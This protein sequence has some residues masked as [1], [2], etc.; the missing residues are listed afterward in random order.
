V[1]HAL[2]GREETVLKDALIQLEVAGLVFRR[3]EPSETIYSFKHALVQDAAYESMLKSR[4]QVLHQRI[5]ETLCERFP[6]IA[7]AEPEV[8]A[9]HFTQAH[10]NEAAI[11]W[12]TKAGRQA[13]K[14]S[15]YSEAIAH[16][17]KAITIADELPDQ[18][19]RAQLSRLHLQVAYG[20]ALRGGLG[21]S[22]PEAV[23]AW[24]RAREFATD[25]KDPAE[26]APIH[27]GLFNASLTHGELAPM[28]EV[29]ESIMAAAESGPKSPVAGVVAHWTSGLTCWFQGDYLGA[30]VHLEQA[31][32]ICK[33]EQ[34][35]DIFRSL[36]LDVP[37][38]VTRFL[39][40]ALWPLGEINRSHRLADEA[41]TDVENK[42]PLVQA[43]ELVHKTVFDGL[44][45]HHRRMMEQSETVL[46][47]AR[48]HALPL[49]VAAGTYLNGLAKWHAGDR[50]TGLAEMQRGWVL[51]HEND[52]YL[53]EP[54]WGLQVAEAEAAIGQIETGLAT[55]SK[56]IVW[57]KQTGQHWLDAE[58]FRLRGDLLRCHDPTNV[59]AAEDAFK[60]AIDIARSQRTKTFEL[61]A[62]LGLARLYVAKGRSKE[63]IEVLAPAIAAFDKGQDLP[64]IEAGESLLM[65]ADG[66]MA[67][68]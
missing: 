10:L 5:A 30:K 54:F 15:A 7:D 48:E 52:C 20:R 17:G 51:L 42:R 63:V 35:P 8:V 26:L 60:C 33:A 21:Y 47:L 64:E 16:L 39:G 3:S 23:A 43:N 58:L 25:I 37:A 62:A 53:Y 12:W 29:A 65:A 28:R 38:A 2:A 9:H 19:G 61:R 40:L 34:S 32:A 27:S 67:A 14:R 55:L 57:S 6:K 11:E 66:R 18:S 49:Y 13:L 31:L 44:C 41:V 68:Q 56:L 36:T 24:A 4:R 22:A 45:G 50:Q 46:A 59:A 1:L